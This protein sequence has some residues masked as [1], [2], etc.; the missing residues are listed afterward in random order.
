MKEEVTYVRVSAKRL[1]AVVTQNLFVDKRRVFVSNGLEGEGL[2]RSG[3]K[4][5]VNTYT[6]HILMIKMKK[7]E[8]R[9]RRKKKEGNPE[10]RK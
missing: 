8:K 1:R 10:E 2:S 7:K 3:S 6:C 5:R 9:K 4:G